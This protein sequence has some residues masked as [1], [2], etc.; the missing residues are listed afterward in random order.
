MDIRDI[1]VELTNLLGH[2]DE[3]LR[4]NVTKM[5]L[6]IESY[7]EEENNNINSGRASVVIDSYKNQHEVLVREFRQIPID[8]KQ[9]LNRLYKAQE[10]LVTID[11]V[12]YY[13]KWAIARC[14]GI[15]NSKL[16]TILRT[17]EDYFKEASF[18]WCQI[19]QSINSELK[20]N[21][22]VLQNKITGEEHG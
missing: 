14:S 9:I 22:V 10:I 4:E 18:R 21:T 17:D 12:M 5:V 7:I 3:Y 2:S 6:N 15:N 20:L 11:T 19:I 13:I 8:K 1:K 16:L